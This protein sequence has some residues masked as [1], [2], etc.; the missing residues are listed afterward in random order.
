MWRNA[1]LARPRAVAGLATRLGAPRRK[2]A[3]AH[4]LPPASLAAGAL[5]RPRSGPIDVAIVASIDDGPVW[6]APIPV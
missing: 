3:G 1:L 5:P 4:R 2:R 6:P